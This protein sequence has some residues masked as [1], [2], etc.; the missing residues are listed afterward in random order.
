MAYLKKEVINYYLIRLILKKNWFLDYY[1]MKSSSHNK[2]KLI[3]MFHLNIL[4]SI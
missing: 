1:Y 3:F 2:L 4:I